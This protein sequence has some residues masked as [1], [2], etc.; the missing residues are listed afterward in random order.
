MPFLVRFACF[1]ARAY[2]QVRMAAISRININLCGS[3]CGISIGEVGPS[4]MALEDIAIFR[5]VHSST[6]LYPSDSI[7]AERLTEILWSQSAQ[8]YS[9]SRAAPRGIFRICIPFLGK[10]GSVSESVSVQKQPGV[11]RK[12]FAAAALRLFGPLAYTMRDMGRHL[13][14]SLQC[15]PHFVSRFST[16]PRR[17]E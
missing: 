6:V 2:D 12:H 11:Y 7:S 17:Q 13:H 1:R 16:L 8:F 14:I 9:R 3:H 5:A 10:R 4:Q 15:Q